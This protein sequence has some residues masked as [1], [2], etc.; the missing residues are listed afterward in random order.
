[1]TRILAIH[2]H[3]DDIE[4]L[5]AATLALLAGRGHHITIATVT[6]GDCGSTETDNEETARIRRGEAADAAKVIGAQY[7]CAGLPDLGVFNDDKSRRWVTETIRQAAPEL[8]ITASPADY[9]PDHEATSVLVRDACFAAPVPN[10]KTGSAAPL[11]EIPHLYFCDPIEG[12]DRQNNRV[13]AE[14]AVN[15]ERF[16]ETKKKMLLAHQSQIAWVEK[17]HGIADYADAMAS[18]T[19][20]RGKHFGVGFAEGFRQYRTHPYPASPLLQGLVGGALLERPSP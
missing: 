1:M 18:W 13:M 8:V 17:Q 10:Y 16:F 6:A 15:V 11:S 3:P 19:R 9:H 4:T 2:A 7:L 5:C 12:R 20:R 14:F